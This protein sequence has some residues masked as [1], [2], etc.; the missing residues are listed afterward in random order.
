[1]VLS[2]SSK[3]SL[4]YQSRKPKYFLTEFFL[5]PSVTYISQDLKMLNQRICYNG[6][7]YIETSQYGVLEESFFLPEISWFLGEN[8]MLGEEFY[9]RYS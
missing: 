8:T 1:M 3:S 4:V 2:K 5:R 6:M 7:R 9:E